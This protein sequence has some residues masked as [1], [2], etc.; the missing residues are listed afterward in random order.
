MINR[1]MKKAIKM[2]KKMHETLE[3]EVPEQYAEAMGKP[4]YCSYCGA[5]NERKDK[6]CS[7]CGALLQR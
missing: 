5:R 2:Q 3:K 6:K 1:M 4:I 7:E